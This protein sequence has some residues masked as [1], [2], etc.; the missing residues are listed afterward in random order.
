MKAI[1]YRKYGSPEVLELQEVGRPEPEDDE[2]LVKVHAASINAWDWDLL[3]G[4]PFLNR[5]GG[6]FEPKHSI[7][8]CD[9]AGRVEAAGKNAHDFHEGD[10]V[11]GDL[12]RSGWGAFAE[13]VCANEDALA[14]KPASMTFEEAAAIPQAGA[15]ALQGLRHRG[16]ISS[17]QKILI[18][19]AGGGVGTI[20]VQ[21]A[22]HHGAEVTCV[23]SAGKLE[24]LRSIGAD[25]VIDYTREDFTRNGP[26]YDL[27]LDVV[28]RRSVSDLKRALAPNGVYVMV[29]GSMAR[30][31]Q[32]LLLGPWIRVLSGKKMG[33]LMHRPNREDLE[34][35]SE[36]YESGAVSPVVDR[37]CELHEVPE[38]LRDLG[39]GRVSGKVVVAVSS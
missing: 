3:R 19:G 13:F 33:I 28:G 35:I 1:V 12:S 10:E 14:P 25:H 24:M 29:G 18:N 38:A 7:L 26:R 23:D 21:I 39:E 22:K 5:L 30:T 9:V 32:V 16:P 34:T 11:F 15:L 17:G 6:L 36:L 27:I 2:V 4:K 37:R 20:A 31:F 8:G